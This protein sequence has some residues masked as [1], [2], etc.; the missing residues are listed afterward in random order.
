MDEG[1]GRSLLVY[2]PRR[3]AG[4]AACGA[5]VWRALSGNACGE[6]PLILGLDYALVAIDAARECVSLSRG[7]VGRTGLFFRWETDTLVIDDELPPPGANE[8]LDTSAF[9]AFLAN[10]ASSVPN[11][12]VHTTATLLSN[13]GWHRVIRS[14]VIEVSLRSKQIS[15]CHYQLPEDE[16]YRHL[17][18]SDLVAAFRE[19]IIEHVRS[20]ARGRCAVE[21]SGGIDSGIVAAVLE[22]ALRG[23]GHFGVSLTY[24][25]YE[26]RHEPAYIDAVNARVGWTPVLLDG[27]RTLLFDDPL[28]VIDTSEPTRLASGYAQ[29]SAVTQ[30]ALRGGARVLFSGHGADQIFGMSPYVRTTLFK[31]GVNLDLLQS[32]FAGEVRDH[33]ASMR[34]LHEDGDPRG[35]RHFFAALMLYDRWV[36][37]PAPAQL[38]CDPGLLSVD[39]LRLS[40]EV[41]RRPRWR[42]PGYPGKPFARE[43]FADWLPESVRVRRWKVGYDGLYR[44]GFARNADR[45]I[46][47][48]E[49][50]RDHLEALGVD[51]A[52]CVERLQRS[53]AFHFEHM[54]LLI[55]IL[56]YCVWR[57]TRTRLRNI[58][59]M[60][61]AERKRENDACE[62]LAPT[63]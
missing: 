1:S 61:G 7:G 19:A 3:G 43:A 27:A 62:A 35:H 59:P 49:R 31:P 37:S 41:F 15:I 28:H 53:K 58:A 32:R 50:E 52:R 9:A 6:L 63:G 38:A 54:E 26:F 10:C 20:R 17:S 11:D 14:S 39:T 23:N 44:R 55:A 46:S 45:L 30:A 34:R 47:G 2:S 8:S 12:V 57:E 29:L 42:E 16:P 18:D 24:P 56:S 36:P 22:R 51:S 48:I 25:Y 21:L 4:A 40:W 60:N 13:H 5:R 33:I